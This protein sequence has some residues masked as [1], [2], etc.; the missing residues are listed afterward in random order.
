MAAGQLINNRVSRGE[1]SIAYTQARELVRRRPDNAQARFTLAYVLRYAG[2]LEESA[3][4]CDAALSIDP[5][6]YLLR[7]CALAFLQLGRT[8]RALDYEQLDAG[9][10]YA[11]IVSIHRLLREGKLEEVKKTIKRLPLN[12]SVDRELLEAC[13]QPNAGARLD[14]IAS[15]TEPAVF[16]DPDPENWYLEGAIMTFCGKKEIAFRMLGR[17]IQH[18]YC[19]YSALQS[20]P[21]LAK[22]REVPEFTRLLS[23]AKQCQKAV[24]GL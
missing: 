23:A 15:Q 13:L 18:N 1:L 10:E 5:G 4:E 3:Q 16:S 6:S 12:V 7:S 20:D 2:M 21:L 9:S 11:G 14:R 19:A 22:L 24:A 17:A 8:Q